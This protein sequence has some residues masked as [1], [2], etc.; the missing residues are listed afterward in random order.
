[1]LVLGKICYFHDPG[2]QDSI[3]S[4]YYTDMRDVLVGSLWAIGVFLFS[5]R[6]YDTLE[7]PQL[8]RLFGT[9]TDFLASSLA[10]ICA[11]GVAIF[12]TRP[13]LPPSD[14]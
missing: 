1:M 13:A 9:S 10:G 14:N 2:I 7:G 12:P 8:R 6:G 3:S 5:Y 11:V 4:Y